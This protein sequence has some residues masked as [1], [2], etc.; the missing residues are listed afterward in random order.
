MPNHVQN[1]VDFNCPPE[2]IKEIL[3]VIQADDP[4]EYENIGLGTI[5]FQKII[6]C[7]NPCL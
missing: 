6:P 2:R 5:D 1:I 7:P 4:E 3:T